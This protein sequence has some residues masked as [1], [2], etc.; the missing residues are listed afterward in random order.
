M[1][2]VTYRGDSG[3]RA[4]VLDS[5]TST[6]TDA[7]TAL[8]EPAGVA[9]ADLV[10]RWDTV[11]ATL[12]GGIRKA[13]GGVPLTD[14]TLL[15]PVPVPARN[16][17]CVGKNYRDHSAEFARSGFDASG[18]PD[19]APEIPS[20]PVIFTKS[21]GSVIGPGEPIDPHA[22]LTSSLDYEAELAVII[23][24]GGRGIPAGRAWDH[25]WGYTII[26][27]VTARD[28]QR[29]H[30]QWFLGKSLD[31]FCPMG[32]WAVTAD[33]VNAT[34]LDVTCH[35]NGELRQK[36]STRDLIFGIPELIETLSAGITLR[37]GDIIATG[38][39]AGVGIGFTPPRFLT[40]GDVVTVEI[41]GLGTLT[42][43]VRTTEGA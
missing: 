31:T 41:E 36:A 28:L 12:A 8:G 17:M 35:V 13:P 22:R 4:G 24:P 34:S 21:P 40:D 43:P 19:G 37:P 18:G 42:N 26:N 33:E 23:G 39:P 6:V 38:T 15:A 1:K 2:L 32:P 14:L 3:P 27:D 5:G 30:K 9:V 20:R 11:A 16:I 25:V 10:A 29:D 7:G